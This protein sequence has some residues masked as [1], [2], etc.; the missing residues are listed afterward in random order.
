MKQTIP[1]TSMRD[2][3]LALLQGRELD[4]VPFVMYDGIVAPKEALKLVGPERLGLLRWCPIFRIEHPNCRFETQE[5]YEGPIR[6]QQNIL[7]TPVG[8]IDELR[9]F[10]PALD[11][12]SIRK[13]YTKTRRL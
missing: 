4:H 3:M 13:H 10:E 7:H 1:V 12:A 9:G 8:S 5:H 6:W 11:S 2:R